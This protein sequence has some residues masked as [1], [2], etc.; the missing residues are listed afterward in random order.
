MAFFLLYDG[1]CTDDD[2]SAACKIGVAHAAVAV[3]GAAGG[4][5]GSGNDLD[6]FLDIDIRIVKHG[7]G[8]V[9]G[10]GEVVGRHVSGHADGDT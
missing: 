8:C 9:D 4:K 3:D 2:T 1:A 7:N 6:E 10:L 5:I